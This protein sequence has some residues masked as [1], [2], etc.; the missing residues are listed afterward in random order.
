MF[1]VL[2]NIDLLAALQLY[3]QRA[4]HMHL[5]NLPI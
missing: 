5:E 4:L 2:I 1:I 3:F